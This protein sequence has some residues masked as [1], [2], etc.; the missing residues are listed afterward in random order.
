M[1][2]IV[3]SQT[4]LNNLEMGTHQQYVNW[5]KTGEYFDKPA[6]EE[7][8][9]LIFHIAN[10]MPAGST[11]LDIG[12]YYGL[13][14]VALAMN[15]A[16]HVIT[17]DVCDRIPEDNEEQLTIRDVQNIT[18]KIKDVLTEPSE[19]L[20]QAKIIVFDVD[21]H[22]GLQEAET[23]T[24]LRTLG[25]SGIVI[26][27]DINLNDEMKTLWDSTPETKYDVTA[28]GHWSGTG[29]ICFSPEYTFTLE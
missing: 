23:L 15:E 19:V 25:F 18:F 7:I 8:Y 29:I 9:R 12:T 28:Y 3:L 27:D 4:D 16:C 11:F 5:T 13:S 2:N 17:Y 21:P 10:H 6:G 22:D 24:T 1:V 20:S 26:L 14:A